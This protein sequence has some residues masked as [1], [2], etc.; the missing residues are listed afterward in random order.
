M[1]LPGLIKRLRIRRGYLRRSLKRCE[2]LYKRDTLTYRIER[3][4]IFLV[5]NDKNYERN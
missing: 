3:I 1:D 2:D 5:K 4:N